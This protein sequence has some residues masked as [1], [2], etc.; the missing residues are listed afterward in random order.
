[1]RK[2]ILSAETIRELRTIFHRL[3]GAAEKIR[4]TQMLHGWIHPQSLPHLSRIVLS[5]FLHRISQH[6]LLTPAP[7]LCD[8]FL[9]QAQ[10]VWQTY[11]LHGALVHIAAV[12][13]AKP[14]RLPLIY[15]MELLKQ[16]GD[17]R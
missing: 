9:I 4:S 3:Q 1:M 13:R 7:T 11:I 6:I 8:E 10:T 15:P 16:A 17:L 12:D 2:S 14:L 5:P